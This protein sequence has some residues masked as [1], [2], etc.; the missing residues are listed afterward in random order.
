MEHIQKY[1]DLINDSLFEEAYMLLEN[2]VKILENQNQIIDRNKLIRD[3]FVGIF[4]DEYF[5][6]L[7]DRSVLLPIAQETTKALFGKDFL[8]D[9]IKKFPNYVEEDKIGI[10][11]VFLVQN[12]D[13]EDALKLLPWVNKNITNY[14]ITINKIIEEG[15]AKSLEFLIRNMQNIHF[16]EGALLRSCSNMSPDILRIM[17]DDLKFDI[18]EQSKI[19]NINKT[20]GINLMH[21]LL[22]DKNVKNFSFIVEHYGNTID[23]SAKALFNKGKQQ[24]SVLELVEASGSY[25]EFYNIILDNLN[26]KDAI[27][28]EIGKVLL[29]NRKAMEQCANSD[30]YEKLFTHNNFNPKTTDLQQNHLI[31]GLLSEIGKKSFNGDFVG[32]KNYYNILNTFLH[33]YVSHDETVEDASQYNVVGA[34]INVVEKLEYNLKANNKD[35]SD[36]KVALDAA[37]LIVR[38]YKQYVN[39]PNPDGRLSIELTVRDSNAYRL[40]VNNGALTAEPE[41]GF[42][43]ALSRMIGGRKRELDKQREMI[44]EKSKESVYKKEEEEVSG[45]SSLINLKSQMR[46]DF[47]TMRGYLNHKLCDPSIKFKCE[48]MFLKSEKLVNLMEKYNVTKSFEDMIFLGKNFSEYLK[49]SLKSYI[50]VC[51][52]THDF[53]DTNMKYEKL[54][55][56]RKKC[57]SQVDLLAEQ[58]ELINQNI[59]A[60]AEGN[61]LRNLNIQ[62]RFLRNRFDGNGN[63]LGLGEVI[64]K[65]FNENE[66]EQ[67]KMNKVQNKVEEVV[68]VPL[69]DVQEV[70]NNDEI[71]NHNEESTNNSEEV[72]VNVLDSVKR[73]KI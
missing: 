26:L 58:V 59:S 38:R 54:E 35:L 71:T 17:I 37:T 14:P 64:S 11:F 1:R 62:G 36:A 67:K 32:A 33:T 16:N 41:S 42:F 66:N 13:F 49:E 48:N 5:N 51:E 55:I 44:I 52:A 21:T 28:D 57:L 25:A 34:A 73:L 50:A 53:S 43:N 23:W 61:A 56:V 19:E 10:M 15:N 45:N 12:H 18:N 60:E 6:E 72:I 63:D 8:K 24:F 46:E 69:V 39:K 3:F 70:K 22:I 31:Y 29:T 65:N 9:Q 7:I 47:R 68:V 20:E 30:V 27:V 40:L 4:D 2:D